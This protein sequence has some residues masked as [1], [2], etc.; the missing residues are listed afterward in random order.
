MAEGW[1]QLHRQLVEWEWYTDA[2]TFR[3]FMHILLNANHSENS[4]RGV[5]IKPGQFVTGRK[6]LAKDLGLSE[7][8][9]RT[10]LNNLQSTSEITIKTTNKYSIISIVKWSE[11]QGKQPA[12]KPAINQPDNQQSTTNNNDNN[13]NN[14]IPPINPPQK[15]PEKTKPKSKPKTYRLPED[16]KLCDEGI[17]FAREKGM[18]DDEIRTTA[19]EFKLY[20][21]DQSTKRPGWHRTWCRWI[22]KKCESRGASFGSKSTGQRQGGNDVLGAYTRVLDRAEAKDALSEE[23]RNSGGDRESD[24]PWETYDGSANGGIGHSEIIDNA[25]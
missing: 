5:V 19:E 21:L 1:M 18:T 17:K 9:I 13:F 22:I 3:V 15:T 20:W 12:E 7:Q 14:I 25:T 8:Q 16:W 2:N 11:Y 6:A 23:R 24:N 4:W 10:T